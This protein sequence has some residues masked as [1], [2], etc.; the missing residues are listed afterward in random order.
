MP[1][2]TGESNWKSEEK[3][4]LDENP[5]MYL[6]ERCSITIIIG[7]SKDATQSHV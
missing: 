1:C 7:N 6:L 2:K 3:P 5:G 4:N